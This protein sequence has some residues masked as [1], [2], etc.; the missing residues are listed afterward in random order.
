MINEIKIVSQYKWK[1][2]VCRGGGGA[3]SYFIF[4]FKILFSRDG[5]NYIEYVFFRNNLTTK[6]RIFEKKNLPQKKTRYNFSFKKA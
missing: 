5:R 4:H 3:T 1:G 6:L 2:G